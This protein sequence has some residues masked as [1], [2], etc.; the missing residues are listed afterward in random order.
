VIRAALQALGSVVR[1]ADGLTVEEVQ[2]ADRSMYRVTIAGR[3][4]PRGLRYVLYGGARALAYA[5]PSPNQLAA[6]AIT[7]D[8]SV[9][10]APLSVGYGTLR[11]VP[12]VGTP[13]TALAPAG[14]VAAAPLPGPYEVTRT[15][16]DLGD[17]VYQPPGLGGK[18]ELAADVHHPTD[19][20]AGPYPLVLFLHGNHASC[21]LGTR[22]DY[23]WPCRAGWEPIPNHEGYAYIARRLAAYGYVVVSISGNGV[24]VLGNF[25][26]DTGMRQRGLLVEKHIDLWRDW[27]TVGG[28]PFGATF[29][30]AIDLDRI[31][32]MGHSRG[33]EGVVW[34][35]IVDRERS[36]PYGID[37]VL[38]LAP[39]DFTRATVNEV[40]LAVMLPYC[41]GDVYDLQGIH[42]FDDAR[43]LEPGD[44][45]PK[46]TVTVFGA[47]HNFF[48]TVWTPSGGYPG[49]FDDTWFRCPDRLTEREQRQVGSAY[50]V[51]FFRRYV[52]GDLSLDP[53]WTGAE[54]PSIGA[55]R[56]LVSYLAPD[57]AGRRMDVDRF[58][59]ASDLGTN[60]Q[61]G[62]VI[63]DSLPFYAWC[64]DIFELP[65]FNERFA[66]TDVHLEGLPQGILA[67]SRGTGSLRFELPAG[68]RD[69]SAFDAFQ[70]RTAL[71]PGSWL[72]DGISH[73]DLVV[74]LEDG[75]G[76]T[77]EVGASDVGNDALANPFPTA[78]SFGH[79]I[80]NQVRFPLE[81][82]TGIDLS[83][84]RAVEIVFSRVAYGKI[85]VADLAFSAGAA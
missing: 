42:L 39:V 49:A 36:D 33:G 28:D 54:A 75:N 19:L 59:D 40:P 85:H 51:R 69:V 41:D 13:G 20:T 82:F 61:G 16:Y 3:F 68:S 10:T 37:A 60:E 64:A 4:P 25:V 77:A 24:N 76:D 5:V 45:S 22:S 67:W 15:A 30:G 6:R 48:N 66:Y 57:A 71:D 8:R 70:L 11:R 63:V 2:V 65:C 72:N 56:T 18:V 79:I 35:V 1:T 83:D 44:A 74:V 34:N 62:D 58:T 26:D 73:Q 32:T 55:A 14:P 53:M 80:L 29:V 47:N 12:Q 23:R 7:R 9:L 38:P 21:F 78:R 17:R 27:S 84:I 31:G 50:I 52:G 81:L 46:H 43:Y